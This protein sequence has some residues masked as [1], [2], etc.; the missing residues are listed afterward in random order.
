MQQLIKALCAERGISGDEGRVRAVIEKQLSG[1]CALSVDPLGNLI[2]VKSGEKP[3]KKIVL[4]AHMDE[5]GILITAI[6]GEGLLK[7]SPIGIDPRVLHGR[8]VRIGDAGILGVIG[9][10]AWHHLDNDEREAELKAEGLYIDIGACS[11]EEAASVVSLGDA[12]CFDAP[13]CEFGEGML[14]SRALDDR[15]GCALLIDL[16]SSDCPWE[17]TG[18]FTCGEES[19]MFGATAAANATAPE[20]AIILETTTAGDIEGAP[21]DKVVCALKKGPVVS[22]ADKGTLYDR[23]LYTLAFNVAKERGIEIQTKEGIFGANE[24]RVVSRAGTGAKTMAISVPCR[25]LHSASSVAAMQDVTAT[26]QLLLAI[27]D[28][29]A[30]L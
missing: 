24:A 1:K 14:L 7:F 6:T 25:Y 19:S 28:P 5:V 4:F 21:A 23:E 22:F 11:K 17:L 16:L 8:R 20:I 29:L 15:V 3:Q 10:K 2:A 30:R 26:K 9:A 27:I 13:F 18:V 12:A